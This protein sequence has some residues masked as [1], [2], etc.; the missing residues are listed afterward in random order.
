MKKQK[1]KK[2]R[3]KQKDKVKLKFSDYMLYGLTYIVLIA[4][5]YPYPFIV[6]LRDRIYLAHRLELLAYADGYGLLWMISI[7]I[8]EGLPIWYFSN[9]EQQKISAVV[10][11]K[12]LTST[13]KR[14]WLTIGFTCIVVLSL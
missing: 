9:A 10:A 12:G 5:M 11:W 8:V 3:K 2:R 13:S 4:L 1:N 6:L 7:V 14:K